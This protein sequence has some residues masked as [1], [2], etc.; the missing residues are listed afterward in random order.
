EEERLSVHN[1]SKLL[2]DAT[3]HGSLLACAVEV[4]MTTYGTTCKYMKWVLKY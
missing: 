4:V 2:N 1:F 3:F